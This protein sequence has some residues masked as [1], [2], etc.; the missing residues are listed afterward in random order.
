[1]KYCPPMR[2]NHTVLT[3]EM[4]DV[5]EFEERVELVPLPLNGRSFTWV[6]SRY[7]SL[8]DR[9]SASE[10]VMQIWNHIERLKRRKIVSDHVP[11]VFTTV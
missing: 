9:F 2:L 7:G 6:N 10:G 3:Q 5:V 4:V 8:L 11:I 1:M